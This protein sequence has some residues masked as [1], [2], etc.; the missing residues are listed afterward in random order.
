MRTQKIII[1]GKIPPPIGGVTTSIKNLIVALK[2]KGIE[3][4]LINFTAIFSRY[5]VAHIHYSNLFKRAVA[6]AF[7]KLIADKVMF[8]VHGKY[9]NLGKI[10]NKIS[11]FFANDIILLNEELVSQI[12]CS[13][14]AD[15]VSLLP[16]LYNEGLQ[17]SIDERPLFSPEPEKKLLLIYAYD[18]SYRDGEEVYGVEFILKHLNQIPD[19]YKIVLL[20]VS[21][22]Y[23]PLIPSAD[24]QIIY[25]DH[26]V[27]FLNLLRQV[28][29][30][31][32]P[33]CMDGASVAVQEAL[34]IGLPV[35]A[36][37]VVDRPDGVS[38][39]R[40]KDIQDFLLKLDTLE[41]AK[42]CFKLQ[43]INAYLEVC[44]RQR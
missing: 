21:G 37:D 28:D 35:L 8:T 33:T 17:N 13:K 39:Y 27:D 34:M 23:A 41:P 4:R 24:G 6:V 15:K 43:S 18:R 32:R 44:E 10:S 9:L 14:Y 22:K 31:L 25:I 29:G 12:K 11:A 5:D 7:A 30:Y 36:S 3:T 16:S 42:E 1:F 38:I 40:Y 20:D 19:Q 2:T 26:E